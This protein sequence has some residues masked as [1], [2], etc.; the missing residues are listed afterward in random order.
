[1]HEITLTRRDKAK[2]FANTP[3]MVRVNSSER[4][5]HN[6]QKIIVLETVPATV[7][8]F[9][10]D[11]LIWEGTA[12]PGNRGIVAL[13]VGISERTAAKLKLP[14]PVAREEKVELP[15]AD[16]P[17]LSAKGALIRRVMDE[18]ERLKKNSAIAFYFSGLCT[19]I[20]AGGI[21]SSNDL[22][23]I[24]GGMGAII[25]IW[26]GI[27]VRRQIPPACRKCNAPTARRTNS[28]EQL[29]AVRSIQ[30]VIRNQTTN[31]NEQ[32]TVT[33]SDIDVVEQW[34]CVA[35]EHVWTSRYTYTRE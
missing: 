20:S 29:K 26:A 24:V 6:G 9:F 11:M 25:S 10:N 33:V 13:D 27:L 5:M 23:T 12:K 15:H 7:K 32:R 1:M 14:P 34:E 18:N 2:G 22:A 31:E 19:L 30:R 8:V 4:K 16:T 28:N 17:Y 35:C 3:F 21:I